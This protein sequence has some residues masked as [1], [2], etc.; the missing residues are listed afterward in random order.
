MEETR[1]NRLTGLRQRN[2][3][4]EKLEERNNEL[5]RELNELKNEALVH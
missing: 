3:E 2:V 4:L 1:E 5:G